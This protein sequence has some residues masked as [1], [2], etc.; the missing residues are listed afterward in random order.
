VKK[1]VRFT[2]KGLSDVL[3]KLN[4][5]PRKSR[6][7]K[8]LFEKYGFEKMYTLIVDAAFSPLFPK[9]TINNEW[10]NPSDVKDIIGRAMIRH[11]DWG[12]ADQR[13][14]GEKIW[15]SLSYLQTPKDFRKSFPP[16]RVKRIF[17]Q[18]LKQ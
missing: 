8:R 11:I 7:A 14:K 9:R 15:A 12:Q 10:W 1:P 3:I 2:K 13:L 17:L 5:C 6:Q 18:V 16:A 4:A